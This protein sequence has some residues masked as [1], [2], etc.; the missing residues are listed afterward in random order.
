[1]TQETKRPSKDMQVTIARQLGLDPST[2]SNFF[3]NA[4][5]RSIDKW[6][7][8][9]EAS[10]ANTDYDDDDDEDE[11]EHD[12]DLIINSSHQDNNVQIINQAVLV[13][14]VNMQ[15]Q[16]INAMDLWQNHNRTATK[17]IRIVH[18]DAQ[19]SN[20][21]R[22]ILIQNN[23][24]RLRPCEMKKSVADAAVRVKIEKK[25]DQIN[26]L[27]EQHEEIVNQDQLCS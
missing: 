1:M 20:N 13:A 4:R 3:M 11:D 25:S 16:D 6:K 14:P 7:D 12:D 17:I 2:V 27:L 19:L 15:L 24:H 8:E 23:N 18:N 21:N 9:N 22:S 5:R 10:N 26:Q